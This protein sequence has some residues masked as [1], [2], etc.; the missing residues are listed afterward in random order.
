MTC[1]RY[2]CIPGDDIAR[3]EAAFVSRCVSC[4]GTIYQLV[5]G[6]SLWSGQTATLRHLDAVY[7]PGHPT[8]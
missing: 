7:G 3:T 8:A 4:E 1:N 6:A 2:G 5:H